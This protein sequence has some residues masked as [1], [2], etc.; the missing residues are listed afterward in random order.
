[1]VGKFES[2]EGLTF[3]HHGSVYLGCSNVVYQVTIFYYARNWLK[4]LCWWVVG[5]GVGGWWWWLRPIIVLSLAQA[6]QYV[7]L[8]LKRVK[9]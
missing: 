7:C 4:S 6:E 3:S 5:G 2:F 1:M 9:K 8:Q